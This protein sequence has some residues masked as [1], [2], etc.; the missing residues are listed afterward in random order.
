M[1]T[2]TQKVVEFAGVRIAVE[3]TPIAFRQ[4]LNEERK[5]ENLK[6]EHAEFIARCKQQGARVLTFDCPACE[7]QIETPAA[8]KDDSWN[9]MAICP[10][11]HELYMK[12]VTDK[13]AEG[14]IPSAH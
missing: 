7:K 9:S 5:V 6:Q 4:Q 8:P 10:H 13:T 11:C 14:R 3:S 1:K 12:L 2:N